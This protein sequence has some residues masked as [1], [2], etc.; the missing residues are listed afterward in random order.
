M[1]NSYTIDSTTTHTASIGASVGASTTSGSGTGPHASVGGGGGHETHSFAT[2]HGAPPP[3]PPT[4]LV[5]NNI[6]Q[7]MG[8]LQQ[9]LINL[10]SAFS[11]SLLPT[12]YCKM[13]L[14]LS[15][16]H[17]ILPQ[18]TEALKFDQFNGEGDPNVHIDSFMTMC[19][20]NNSLDAI[21]LKI[22][23]RSLMGIT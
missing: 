18:G 10:A 4:N 15:I 8:Q 9:Q 16:F 11:Q 22:F 20:D 2:M 21:L 3:A 6:L 19:S 13:L 7:N 5:L 14:N 1:S 17:T 12:Y 23:S